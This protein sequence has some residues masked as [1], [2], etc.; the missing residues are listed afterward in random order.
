[1][2]HVSDNKL[3]HIV[4]ITSYAFAHFA[5][6]TH[7]GFR[8]R[9]SLICIDYAEP[10]IVKQF[11][12]EVTNTELFQKKLLS[13]EA[14][15]NIV[16]CVGGQVEDL[17]RVITGLTRG[18]QYFNILRSMLTDSIIEIEDHLESILEQASQTNDEQVKLQV[19]ER[20]LRFWNL[21]DILNKERHVNKR[22]IVVNV[23]YHQHT[24]ELQSLLS[25]HIISFVNER[26][27]D[28]IGK[29]PDSIFSLLN[30]SLDS[31]AYT[32]GSPK[33]CMAFGLL[34]KDE[35]M[36]KQKKWV[37][38]Q[39]ELRSLREREKECH[40]N[41][42]ALLEERSQCLVHLE[43]IIEAEEKWIRAIGEDALKQ[44]KERILLEQSQ[45]ETR[46]D[47]ENKILAAIRMEISA[48][49]AK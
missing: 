46:I 28:S 9:R 11:F 48:K 5:L 36:V 44:R 40:Q 39:I 13:P 47:E 33:M 49:T 21:M 31:I 37:M 25:S 45:L 19:Y 1:V 26:F 20:Y 35:K 14:I 16:G 18:D 29:K 10:D 4:Y 2:V 38:Q 7:A 17:D 22:N 8:R 42:K 34:L 43:K 27:P 15:E 30:S 6:D 3:A 23:F 12:N 41:R 24:E 32:A